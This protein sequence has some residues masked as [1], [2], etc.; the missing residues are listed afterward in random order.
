MIRVLHF[1]QRLRKGQR[2]LEFNSNVLLPLSDNLV[3]QSLTCVV[4]L[5]PGRVSDDGL[6]QVTS[7]VSLGELWVGEGDNGDLR[8][9]TNR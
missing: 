2:R 7:W 6:S 8:V 1:T 5:Q 4:F 3:A 9:F